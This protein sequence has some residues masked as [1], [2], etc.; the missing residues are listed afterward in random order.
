MSRRA[1]IALV[2]ATT[3]ALRLWTRPADATVTLRSVSYALKGGLLLSATFPSIDDGDVRKDP[4]LRIALTGDADTALSGDIGSPL[5]TIFFLEGEVGN[6]PTVVDWW[7]GIVDSLVRTNDHEAILTI[8]NPASYLR[9][10]KSR[11]LSH[12]HHTAEYPGDTSLQHMAGLANN[13]LPPIERG[14]P[15]YIGS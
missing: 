11:I 3:P 5:C 13:G 7:K 10:L 12:Q 14:L 15:E 1:D 8:T 9:P 2:L 6:N 4:E